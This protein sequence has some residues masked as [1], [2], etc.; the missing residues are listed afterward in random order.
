V[1]VSGSVD[2]SSTSLPAFFF[3]PAFGFLPYVSL[4]TETSQYPQFPAE[5]L[6]INVLGAVLVALAVL[7]PVLLLIFRRPSSTVCPL[8][9]EMQTNGAGQIA[10]ESERLWSIDFGFLQNSSPS[11]SLGMPKTKHKLISKN[12]HKRTTTGN[13]GEDANHHFWLTKQIPTVQKEDGG[14]DQMKRDPMANEPIDDI[15]LSVVLCFWCWS[16]ACTTYQQFH[17]LQRFLFLFFHFPN[18]KQNASF[19][20]FS[21]FYQLQ[22][23]LS[24]RS[25]FVYTLNYY[26]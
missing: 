13:V 10:D 26:F 7:V 16:R 17:Q 19:F 12:N 15:C 22:L 1:V 5:G 9:T 14:S 8:T 25:T 6:V 3:G 21:Q 23:L 2:W 24:L 20:A 11:I 4:R 18:E